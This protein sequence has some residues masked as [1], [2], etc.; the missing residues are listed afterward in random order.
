MSRGAEVLRLT[1]AGKPQP[2]GSLT[3]YV[4]WKSKRDPDTDEPTQDRWKWVPLRRDDGSIAVNVTSDNDDLKAWRGLVT[5]A[6]REQLGTTLAYHDNKDVGFDVEMT[7]Y[8]KRPESHWKADG[9]L[10]DWAPARPLV[11]PDVDKLLR[12]NLDAITK[13]L[14]PDD[15]Q[16]V[17]ATTRKRF[18]VQTAEDEPNIRAE[19]VVW[20]SGEQTAEDLPPEERVRW[21]PPPPGQG[22]L[23]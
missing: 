18:A 13:V 9:T 23:C 10:K 16:V 15:A 12:A 11:A 14:W 3:A 1:I 6:A 19:I 20:I 5:A 7:S 22:V 17:D 4:L 21:T 2:Q 8:L